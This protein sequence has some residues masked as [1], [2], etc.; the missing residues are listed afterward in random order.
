MWTVPRKYGEFYVLEQKLT[1]FHGMANLF[2][3]YYKETKQRNYLL[4]SYFE[5]QADVVYESAVVAFHTCHILIVTI[6]S[7]R[8]DMSG[9][10][11]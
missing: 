10:I 9:Q 6:I 7:F 2:Q 8:T 4:V 11:V 5:V 3:Y 1:E